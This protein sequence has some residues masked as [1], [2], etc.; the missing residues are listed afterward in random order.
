MERRGIRTDIGDMNRDIAD[1][2]KELRQLRARTVKL[3]KW[4]TEESANITPPMLHDV[5]I[6]I[7]ERRG[8]HNL[9][10]AAKIL[11]FL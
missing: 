6:N 11:I 1:V 8:I 5:I 2:N 7:L 10:S 9:Q 4:I 3:E